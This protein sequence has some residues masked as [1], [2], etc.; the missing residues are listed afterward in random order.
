M[1]SSP[2][3]ANKP[4]SLFVVVVASVF[5]QIKFGYSAVFKL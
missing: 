5:Y 2:L 1:N 3:I 4:T